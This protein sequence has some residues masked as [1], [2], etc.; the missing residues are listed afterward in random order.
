MG[1]AVRSIPG[2][3]WM[4]AVGIVLALLAALLIIS[5]QANGQAPDDWQ[6]RYDLCMARGADVSM[7]TRVRRCESVADQG[8]YGL[9]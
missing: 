5:W 6:H 4:I 9:D 8:S 2:V 1:S 7:E 3:V